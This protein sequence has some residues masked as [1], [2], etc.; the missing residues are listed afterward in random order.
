MKIKRVK[1]SLKGNEM[2]KFIVWDSYDKKFK[3]PQIEVWD[4]SL[5][6]I[7]DY[8]ETENVFKSIGK[9]DINGQ[10]IYADCSIVEFDIVLR[11]CTLPIKGYFFF[12][13]RLLSY[14]I[15]VLEDSG[16]DGK[17]YGSRI[18]PYSTYLNEI[19]DIKIIDTIPENK[20]GLI[21]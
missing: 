2:E 7:N 4:T 21:K 20:L 14:N 12:D 15:K 16:D 10:E 5:I 3:E 9:Q 8:L 18:I 6:N 19:K 1:P 17:K 13:R 11:T